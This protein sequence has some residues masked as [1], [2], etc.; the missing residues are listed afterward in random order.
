MTAI[1]KLKNSG[2]VLVASKD[3]R[4]RL[5][6]DVGPFAADQLDA[7]IGLLAGPGMVMPLGFGDWVLLK[8]EL[9]NSYAQAVIHTL[10][11]DPDERGAIAEERVLRGELQYPPG[12]ERLDEVDESIVLHAMHKQLVERELCFRDHDEQARR[13]TQLIFP[14]YFRRNRPDRPTPPQVLVTYRCRGTLDT[15]YAGLVTRLHHTEAFESRDLWRY[16]ADFAGLSGTRV[17]VRLAFLDEGEGRLEIYYDTPPPIGEQVLFAGY[18]DD[19]LR[20]TAQSRRA[21]ARLP[22]PAMRHG[23]GS[24]RCAPAAQRR[25]DL[26]RVQP[27]R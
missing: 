15:V 25:Q 7:L 14:S 6:L 4:D 10:R 20:R 5:P 17:G 19:H 23:D 21:A 13:A 8:P 9:L 3:L 27:V 1:I 24:G 22:L 18:V 16:A 26:H 12:L 11:S 2:R